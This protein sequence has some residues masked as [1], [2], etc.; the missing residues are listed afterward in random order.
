MKIIYSSYFG[1]YLPVVASAMH[2]DILTPFV[3]PTFEQIFGL[4][5]FGTKYSR[6]YGNFFYIGMDEYNNEVYTIGCKNLSDVMQRA[7]KSISSFFNL[8]DIQY[9]D[10]DEGEMGKIKI[11]IAENLLLL[12][13]TSE[14]SERIIYSHIKNRYLNISKTVL[15]VKKEIQEVE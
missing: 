1:S 6:M 4:P 8:D 2:L 13:T 7:H 10:I 12:Q 15:K 5:Y 11:R 9:Y 14:I 3:L